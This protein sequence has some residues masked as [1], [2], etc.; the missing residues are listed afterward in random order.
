MLGITLTS[1][2]NALE[3]VWNFE[4]TQVCKEAVLV[5]VVLGQ[6]NYYHLRR[7]GSTMENDLDSDPIATAM[8]AL[9]E[10]LSKS[11]GER[12]LQPT[13]SS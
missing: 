10:I 7:R 2:P 11:S 1:S 8:D 6:S 4:K 13:G 5:S 3:G 12:I 9:S